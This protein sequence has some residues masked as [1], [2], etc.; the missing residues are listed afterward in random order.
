MVYRRL[1]AEIDAGTAPATA[2]GTGEAAMLDL[3]AFVRLNPQLYDTYR[4]AGD[5]SMRHGRYAEAIGYYQA[6]LTKEIATM[7]EKEQLE[8]KLDKA[9][10]KLDKVQKRLG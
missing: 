1:K 4:L 7:G 2:T 9:R 8:E 6:A 3:P 10:K 5:Y